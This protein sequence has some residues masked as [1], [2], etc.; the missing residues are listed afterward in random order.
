LTGFV[1]EMV[2]DF[3]EI[4]RENKPIFKD[5]KKSFIFHSKHNL[6]IK[7]NLQIADEEN[8]MVAYVQET[9][10]RFAKPLLN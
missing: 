9:P 1:P 3:I 5:F 10:I 8:S 4:H 2:T 6:A 7:L